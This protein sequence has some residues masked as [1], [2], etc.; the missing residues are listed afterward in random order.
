MTAL[1]PLLT[2]S[3][4]APA[5]LPTLPMT[6]LPPRSTAFS[7][8]AAQSPTAWMTALVP[9]PR[10]SAMAPA[11][12]L[13]APA[14]ACPAPMTAPAPELTA[15]ATAVP[16]RATLWAAPRVF[17]R[18]L[19]ATVPTVSEIFCPMEAGKFTSCLRKASTMAPTVSREISASMVPA[20]RT[21]ACCRASSLPR[22]AKRKAL[23]VTTPA[24]M[25]SRQLAAPSMTADVHCCIMGPM[26]GTLEA[27]MAGVTAG[28][29]S[30]MLSVMV[31]G[32]SRASMEKEMNV[33]EETVL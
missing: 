14:T 5:P 1:V 18:A 33:A 22:A 28:S 26:S 10:A 15:S 4:T 20:S 25:A 17:S 29:S 2:M 19:S 31:L 9:L 30:F 27:A 3:A 32:M 16:P 12:L 21:Q 6:A 11:P 7:A 13:T 23:R 8:L 24:R